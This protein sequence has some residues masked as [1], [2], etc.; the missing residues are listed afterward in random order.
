MTV[1][2]ILIK[3]QSDG[4]VLHSFTEEFRVQLDK[5]NLTR[6]LKI[7]GKFLKKEERGR[8]QFVFFVAKGRKGL[9]IE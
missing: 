7:D 2:Y 3:T 5:F 4:S 9:N 1:H 8:K 6:C